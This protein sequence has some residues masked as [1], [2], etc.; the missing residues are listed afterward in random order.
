VKFSRREIFSRE[1]KIPALAFEDHRLTS[2]AGLI[3]YQIHFMRIGIKESLRSTRDL[4]QESSGNFMSPLFFR[5]P[6]ARD[7]IEVIGSPKES[8]LFT[9]FYVL[10]PI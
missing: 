10:K 6:S 7:F 3:M 1:Y 2:F 4:S 5:I 8:K 9:S